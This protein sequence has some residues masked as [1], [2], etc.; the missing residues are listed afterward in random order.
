MIRWMAGK[1][2][3]K[4]KLAMYSHCVKR[5]YESG[6]DVETSE[7]QIREFSGILPHPFV[8]LP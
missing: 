4:L 7:N 1:T 2:I 6:F 8:L 3:I 5:E